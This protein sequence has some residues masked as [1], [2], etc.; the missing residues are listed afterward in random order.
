MEW[1]YVAFIAV[2]TILGIH[3]KKSEVLQEIKNLCKF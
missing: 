3:T 1:M 2:L